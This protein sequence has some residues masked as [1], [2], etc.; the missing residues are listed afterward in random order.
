M[1]KS[2][3]FQ[4]FFPMQT[5][6]NG[7]NLIYPGVS[8]FDFYATQAPRI[9]SWFEH[10]KP[11]NEPRHPG[12]FKIHFGRDS[13][14]KHKN[15]LLQYYFDDA[16][17]GD[18]AEHVNAELIAEI[19]GDLDV[20]RAKMDQYLK[21]DTIWKQKNEMEKQAQWRF[22]YAAHMV[23]ARSEFFNTIPDI[24]PAPA[25]IK[26]DANIQPEPNTKGRKKD[27]S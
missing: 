21:D 20:W 23:Q 25:S 6:Q 4:P 8:L 14:Y 18:Y 7:T 3:L 1:N 16:W 27:E 5:E 17:C 22:A 15:I 24:N 12:P 9:P 11:P 13:D 19:E 26:T 10:V 2:L